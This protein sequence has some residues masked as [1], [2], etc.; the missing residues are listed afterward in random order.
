MWHTNTQ[1]KSKEILKDNAKWNKYGEKNETVQFS[2][3]LGGKEVEDG[4]IHRRMPEG[5]NPPYTILNQSPK[6][7]GYFNCVMPKQVIGILFIHHMD[8][9]N[10][11]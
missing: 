6:N 8:N 7:L 2:G 4:Y 11:I 5:K 3:W 10:S 1:K 9:G